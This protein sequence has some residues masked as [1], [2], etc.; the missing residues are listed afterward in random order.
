MSD[1]LEESGLAEAFV[2]AMATVCTPVA[3]VTAMDGARP[4]GTTVSAF[5][6]LS[7]DPPMV[8]A[9]LAVRS[10]LLTL[11]QPGG[12]FGLNVLGSGH[13]AAAA[14]FARKGDNKFDGIAWH[15]SHGAPRLEDSPGWLACSVAQLVPAGDH[16]VVLGHVLQAAS[17][18]GAPLTYHLRAFGTHAPFDV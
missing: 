2:N 1:T 6:S 15:E 14:G 5:A 11:L 7:L 3:V 4:H 8:L 10:E 18:P 17:G 13:A 9:S 16:V 12:R